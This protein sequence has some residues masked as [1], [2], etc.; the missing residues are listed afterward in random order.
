MYDPSSSLALAEFGCA[1]LAVIGVAAFALRCR[2][3][4]AKSQGK[5]AEQVLLRFSALM[6]FHS[7]LQRCIPGVLLVV[8]GIFFTLDRSRDHDSD[9]WVGL[10]FIPFGWVLVVLLAR[11]SWRRYLELQRLADLDE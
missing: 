4:L 7:T 3:K 1:L 10:L 8:L 5:T 6:Q 9:W 11:K 2:D